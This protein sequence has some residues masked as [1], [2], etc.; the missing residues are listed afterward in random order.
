V[1]EGWFQDPYGRHDARWFSS[2]SPTALV[3]DGTIERTD[4]P[5]EQMAAVPLVPIE[6]P[7]HAPSYATDLLR[8][9]DAER[10]PPP[11][12]DQYGTVAFDTMARPGFW[13]PGEEKDDYDTSAA[14]RRRL[15]GAVFVAIGALMLIWGFYM[16]SSVT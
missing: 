14:S 2:G 15:R 5:P 8:A 13:H 12:R 16:I 9:D 10:L 6:D 3:R 4:A 7:E 11:T 1:A